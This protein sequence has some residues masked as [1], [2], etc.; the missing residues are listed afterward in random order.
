LGY[1]EGRGLRKTC[2]IKVH[3]FV[4]IMINVVSVR[5]VLLKVWLHRLAWSVDGLR[6]RLAVK[7][8]LNPRVNEVRG[9]IDCHKLETSH[10]TWQSFSYAQEGRQ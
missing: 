3:E 6:A 2:S 9:L 10:G 1:I 8:I 4:L 7:I 5:G